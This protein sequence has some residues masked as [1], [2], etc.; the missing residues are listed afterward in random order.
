MM[1]SSLKLDFTIL[2]G[3]LSSPECVTWRGWK[4]DLI[5]GGA[6]GSLY[7]ID[8]DGKVS[9]LANT[10]GQILGVVADSYWGVVACDVGNGIVWRFDDEGRSSIVAELPNCNFASVGPEGDLFVSTPFPDDTERSAIMRIDRVSMAATRWMGED[11]AFPNGLLWPRS[12]DGMFVLD[13]DRHQLIR[14]PCDTN[15]IR[16]GDVER[17]SF[18]GPISV[19]GMCELEDGSI[20]VGCYEPSILVHYVRGESPLA[21]V[22]EGVVL[23]R[24][25]NLCRFGAEL[26]YLAVACMG[27]G[28]IVV[29]ELPPI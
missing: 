4:G 14:V 12:I 5:A 15:G 26:R 25:T 8:M 20:V 23:Y 29:S 9:T 18:L 19:D 2:A 7:S 11:L 1:I 3:G 21:V 24:P 16:T 17:V 22:P 28:Q 13:T 10:G 27:S 6:D